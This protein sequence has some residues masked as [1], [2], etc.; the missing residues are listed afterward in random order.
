MAPSDIGFDRGRARRHFL[1][2]QGDQSHAVAHSVR[3][4]FNTRRL[5]G[6]AADVNSD[7]GKRHKKLDDTL[8]LGSINDAGA[9]MQAHMAKSELWKSVR[10]VIC[11]VTCVSCVR[12]CKRSIRQIFMD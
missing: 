4:R 2:L 5:G 12:H 1:L 8:H 6:G 3:I 10:L 11:C 9:A 7:R